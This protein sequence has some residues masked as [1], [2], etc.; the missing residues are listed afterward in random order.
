MIEAA[1]TAAAKGGLTNCKF[2]GTTTHSTPLRFTP[3]SDSDENPY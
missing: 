2:E 1:Q 3:S